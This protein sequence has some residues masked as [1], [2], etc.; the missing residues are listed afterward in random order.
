MRCRHR[1][2]VERERAPSDLNGVEEEPMTGQ[3]L[4][5]APRTLG[6]RGEERVPGRQSGAGADGRDVVQVAPRALELE[7]DRA[8]ARELRTGC[9]PSTSSHACA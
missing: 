7:Q 6:E 3:T 9:R 5:Q 2:R 8:D 4:V 1:C